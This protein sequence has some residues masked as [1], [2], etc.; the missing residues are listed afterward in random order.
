MVFLVFVDSPF[1]DPR[2]GVLL[3]DLSVEPELWEPEAWEPEAI[4]L[5]A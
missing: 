3:V 4:E 2:E 5:G 1:E